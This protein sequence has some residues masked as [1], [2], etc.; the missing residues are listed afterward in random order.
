MERG[1]LVD[2]Y[3]RCLQ[4]HFKAV[5]TAIEVILVESPMDR[6][7]LAKTLVRSQ[8]AF[9]FRMKAA[10]LRLASYRHGLSV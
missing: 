8:V 7:D 2:E 6:P 5:S 9:A 1:R 3:L 10:R 4:N